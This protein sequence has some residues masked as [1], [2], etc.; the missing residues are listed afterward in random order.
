[1]SASSSSPP[2]PSD[3]PPNHLK[4]AF[5]ARPLVTH[6]PYLGTRA[7][8]DELGYGWVRPGDFMA[9]WAPAVA[10]ILAAIAE[11][12]A[13]K[14]VPLT[15]EVDQFAQLKKDPRYL[16]ATSPEPFALSLKSQLD[17]HFKKEILPQFRLSPDLKLI[18]SKGLRAKPKKGGQALHMDGAASSDSISVIIYCSAAPGQKTT[19]VPIFPLSLLPLPDKIDNP[20]ETEK[21]RMAAA[22]H[23]LHPRFFHSIDAEVGGIML[24]RQSTPH[25]GTLNE[26]LVDR[27][28]VFD[29]LSVVDFATNPYQDEY[30][31]FRWMYVA[32]AHGFQ[33]SEFVHS[34][35]E[36]ERHEPLSHYLPGEGYEEAQGAL[37]W[38]I[39]KLSHMKLSNA[40]RPVR[41][42][43]QSKSAQSSPTKAHAKAGKK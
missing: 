11:E 40:A 25:Y 8:L 32:M 15:G 21:A 19:A 22:S 24:L 12:Q 35:L 17:E 31:F 37:D 33:S 1:M 5:D 30:Q 26:S 23:L 41:M 38:A 9:K 20:T 6:Q 10:V 42:P 4:L 36:A 16:Y 3:A 14:S 2:V 29:V 7:A 18:G 34:L 28:V 13:T 43:S 27:L 39:E